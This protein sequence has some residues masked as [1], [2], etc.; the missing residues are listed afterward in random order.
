MRFIRN[1]LFLT[2]FL[3]VINDIF[4]IR[5][6]YMLKVDNKEVKTLILWQF[7]IYFLYLCSVNQEKKIMIDYSQVCQGWIYCIIN[8]INGKMYIGKTNN[9]ERRKREHLNYWHSDLCYK[10]RKAY[11][12]YG[13]ENFQ[14]QSLLTFRAINSDVLNKVLNWLEVYYINK[15][16]SFKDGYNA[17]IGG[18]GCSGYH[19]TE[20]QTK[21]RLLKRGE[22]SHSIETKN[23]IRNSLLGRK[24][25][26]PT[27]PK[28]ILQYDLEGNFIR[29]FSSITEAAITI[30]RSIGSIGI[31][32]KNPFKQRGGF[33]WRVKEENNYPQNIEPYN[34]AKN[35]RGFGKNNKTVYF[36]S[37][38]GKL[39]NVYS[40]PK[41]ASIYAKKHISFIYSSI[42][43]NKEL[44]IHPNS[45]YS[46]NPPK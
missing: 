5:A 39:L 1:Y 25:G 9:F 22:Y 24:K 10:I 41:E 40:S 6:G 3:K 23:K 11:K 35:K 38:E 26:A 42:F 8:K 32:L 19:L 13:I 31:A 4:R 7:L 2:V 28:A 16:N 29:E 37:R 21:R 30:N 17:T 15:Y 45:Y 44:K 46:Y 33:L 12:K 14:V 43:R 34:K 36:Y 18:E 20:E 27:H